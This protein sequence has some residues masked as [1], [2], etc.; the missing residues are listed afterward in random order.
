MDCIEYMRSLP[1]NAFDIAVC[2]PPYG[3]GND[4]NLVGGAVRTEI[5]KVFQTFSGGARNQDLPTS[6]RFG[7]WFR[8]YD[9]PMEQA[10]GR[11]ENALLQACEHTGS[12]VGRGQRDT[13]SGGGQSRSSTMGCRSSAGVLRRAFPYQ[14]QSDNMGRQLL[15]PAS[16][17]VFLSV[18]KDENLRTFFNGDG[19]IRMDIVHWE[20]QGF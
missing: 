4:D 11:S 16:D 17:K 1:D 7:G 9:K 15:F 8:R 3:K 18:A 12:A 2:D 5:R 14:P 13:K 6:R 19:R 10:A 20:C